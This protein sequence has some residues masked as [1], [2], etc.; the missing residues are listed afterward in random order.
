MDG[1]LGKEDDKKHVPTAHAVL[2]TEKK[3]QMYWTFGWSRRVTIFS[4]D[5]MNEFLRKITTLKLELWIWFLKLGLF[6]VYWQQRCVITKQ[7]L[8]MLSLS[9]RATVKGNFTEN[10]LS[11]TQWTTRFKQLFFPR[12]NQEQ[13]DRLLIEICH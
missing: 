5:R 7:K 8:P 6:K 10:H 4:L 9:G 2:S 13:E 12:T 3:V 1:A 11:E